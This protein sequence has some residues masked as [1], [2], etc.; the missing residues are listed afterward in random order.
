MFSVEYVLQKPDVKQN[1]LYYFFNLNLNFK[2]K[3][4][5]ELTVSGVNLFD[6]KAIYNIIQNSV[7]TATYENTIHRRTLL[8]GLKYVL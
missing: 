7:S 8:A 1:F 4:K 2:L 5:V 3:N 6:N